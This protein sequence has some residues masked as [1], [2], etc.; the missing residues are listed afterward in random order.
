[1]AKLF[2]ENIYKHLTFELV[3]KMNRLIP[4]IMRYLS[5]L[6]ALSILFVLSC[7]TQPSI[8]N[9]IQIQ[10]DKI[11][12]SL[13]SIRRDIHENPELS[14][15]EIRTS[16][17]VAEHLSSLGLEVRT[18]V[19]GYG[20]VGILQ[21]KTKGK[22][23]GWRAEMDA[24]KTDLPDAVDFKSKVDSV[25]HICGHDVHTTIGL[26]IANV[27]SK[28]KDSVNGTVVFI[29]QPAEES[30]EGAKRMIDDG[31]YNIIKP[32]EIYCLHLDDISAGKVAIK[33]GAFFAYL[34]PLNITYKNIGNK[35]LVISFTKSV[36]NKYST[37]DCQLWDKS[38]D[39]KIGIFSGNSIFKDFVS[40]CDL[41]YLQQNAQLITLRAIYYGTDKK[42]LDSLPEKLT[43]VINQ[44]AYAG[45]FGSITS[46]VFP[47]LEIYD[48][49]NDPKLTEKV[50]HTISTIYGENSI[51]EM[52]GVVMGHGDDFAYFQKDIPGGYYMLGGSNYEKGIISHPHTPDFA[53][54]EKCIAAGVKY[55]SSMI[56]ERLKDE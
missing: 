29:F 12:D 52:D 39:H 35:D 44:S 17:L 16:K 19:G 6:L 31:L 43:G 3:G 32:D 4:I 24:F 2:K 13:V 40:S 25:R 15:N 28:L 49:N 26:G 36:L 20:V 11:Y 34:R 48:I 7:K 45:H 33:S 9:L 22:T 55:F 41:F 27:L 46:V 37:L 18:H 54:D 53:V 1:M 50:R 8:H 56:V 14:F 23:I 51:K 47:G 42:Q 10:A 38:L 5:R 21:G 30:L